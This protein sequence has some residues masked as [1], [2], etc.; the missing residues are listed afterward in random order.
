MRELLERWHRLE[1]ERC[2]SGPPTTHICVVVQV[3]DI[4]IFHDGAHT[5]M[6]DRPSA[7]QRALLLAAVIEAIEAR[8][9][10]AVKH[11][12]DD[13]RG[14]D[15]H[16]WRYSLGG[17]SEETWAEVWSGL[18][19]TV[20]RSYRAESESREPAA[21]LLGAYLAALEAEGEQ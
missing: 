3:G 13:A 10:K 8:D 1:P 5:V 17:H 11:N 19:M 9:A 21:A 15:L 16:E 7:K 4:D 2:M 6:L 20:G 12:A 14:H 18:P